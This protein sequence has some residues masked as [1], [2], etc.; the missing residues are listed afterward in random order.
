M[1]APFDNIVQHLFHQPSL[2]SVTVDELERMAVQHPYFAAAHFLLLKKMQDTDHPGF[3]SQ[4]HKTTLYFNNPLWLQ[5]L[6]QP[7]AV[8]GFTVL[9]KAPFI[10]DN[11]AEDAGSSSASVAEA[12][13]VATQEEEMPLD[14]A[15]Q[16]VSAPQA[17]APAAGVMDIISDL[18]HKEEDIYAASNNQLPK[19][20]PFLL[21]E[22]EK[23]PAQHSVESAGAGFIDT[24]ADAG[25]G[26]PQLPHQ[27]QQ[28]LSPAPATTEPI[29][30]TAAAETVSAA[31]AAVQFSSA[32]AE[33]P[34]EPLAA[35]ADDAKDEIAAEDMPPPATQPVQ[36]SA[37]DAAEADDTD[38]APEP[39][40]ESA[41]DHTD[42]PLETAP[43]TATPMIRTIVELP[44]AHTDTLFEPFHTVD[45]FASQG[46]RLSKAE[47]EPKD[48]LGRQ[49]KSFT[50]WLKTMKKLPQAS[51][52][53]LLTEKEESKVVADAIHSIE[54]KE[55]VTEAMA[56][57]FEKQGLHEKAVQVYQKLSLLNPAKSTY[58]AAKIDALKT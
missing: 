37:G 50:D 55:V 51:M 33:T 28:E 45:Y 17:A 11:H 42:G 48:K 30:Y 5:F 52:D 13:A 27:E 58:F 26:D 16:N 4:L 46:I 31:P 57:V 22:E 7:S 34:Q 23:R 18:F 56:E 38:A 43:S 19:P 54:T 10:P 35:A 49:L 15:P 20:M 21:E 25:S 40:G 6:L 32:D 14:N 9:D 29:E 44:A 1:Q 47:S 8:E 3:T 39:G 36:Q 24:A 41:A 2:Q 53:A 12:P